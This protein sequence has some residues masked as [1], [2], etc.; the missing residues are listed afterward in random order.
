VGAASRKGAKGT[1]F[2]VLA[3]G[4]LREK[5]LPY[6][7]ALVKAQADAVRFNALAGSVSEAEQ[8]L[9]ARPVAHLN[10]GLSPLEV[11]VAADDDFQV[12]GPEVADLGDVPA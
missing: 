11:L 7:Q 3:D 5:H 8:Y 12:A 2:V 1:A 4:T 6:A 9:L 10:Q